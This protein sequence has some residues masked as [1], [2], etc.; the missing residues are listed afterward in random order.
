MA[1]ARGDQ[2]PG[3]GGADDGTDPA[4]ARGRAQRGAANGGRVEVRHVG[5]DQHLRRED[6][7]TGEEDDRVEQQVA[8][9]LDAQAGQHHHGDPEP[10]ERGALD[11]PPV[12]DEAAEDQADDTADVEHQQLGDG[13]GDGIAGVVHQLRQPGVEAVHQQQAHEGG[14]PD[15]DARAQVGGLEQLGERDPRHTRGLPGLDERLRLGQP[16]P[17]DHGDGETRDAE[18]VEEDL[19]VV[20]HLEGQQGGDHGTGVIAGHRERAG[21]GATAGRHV[22]R[23][24]RQRH[25]HAGAQAQTG[26]EAEHR[27]HRDR[28][29]QRHQDGEQG[30]HHHGADEQQTPSKA[31]GQRADADRADGH[32]HQGEGRDGGRVTRGHTEV[33]RLEQSRDDGAED[34]E[35][36]PLEHDGDPAQG[37]G[38]GAASAAA[39][40]CRRSGGGDGSHE[41]IPPKGGYGRRGRR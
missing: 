20:R 41:D 8:V 28:T 18:D 19:P 1:D 14:H 6:E 17:L 13:R 32:A 39:G 29:G 16:E 24:H 11:A 30:E 23:H 5:V 40:R 36:V 22:L 10:A 31:V 27:E 25:R 33:M 35:V 26:E 3:D 37:H 38:P 12:G 2:G 21:P 7:H 4:D 9:H 34:D 15:P